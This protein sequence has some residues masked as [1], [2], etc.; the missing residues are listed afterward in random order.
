M[1]SIEE[2]AEVA[3]VE[4]LKCVEYRIPKGQELRKPAYL[5]SLALRYGLVA[6]AAAYHVMDY[7]D[8][9]DE[10]RIKPFFSEWPLLVSNHIQ[11]EVGDRLPFPQSD[12]MAIFVG[13]RAYDPLRMAI[14]LR[15]EHFPLGKSLSVASELFF[16]DHRFIIVNAWWWFRKRQAEQAFQEVAE[17]S[18]RYAMNFFERR[19]ED[20]EEVP[21][22]ALIGE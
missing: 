10:S 17:E 7:A 15:R 1:R 16:R 22:I 2:R 3:M 14:A 6:S 20:L 19:E 13:R 5:L 8:S 18:V 4:A 11:D 12:S 21:E 9:S